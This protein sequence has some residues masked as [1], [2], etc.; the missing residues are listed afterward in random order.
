MELNKEFVF[1]YSKLPEYWNING[2]VKWEILKRNKKHTLYY[3]EGTP[4]KNDF[5][6]QAILFSLFSQIIYN[7]SLDNYKYIND[8]FSIKYSTYNILNRIS[9]KKLKFFIDQTCR[10]RFANS[11][12]DFINHSKKHMNDY[13]KFFIQISSHID[14]PYCKIDFKKLLISIIDERRFKEEFSDEKNDLSNLFFDKLKAELFKN[15]FTLTKDFI[16]E[17]LL[18]KKYQLKNIYGNEFPIELIGNEIFDG[19]AIYIPSSG[20]HRIEHLFYLNDKVIPEIQTTMPKVYIHSDAC[21]FYKQYNYNELRNELNKSF[22]F[23]IINEVIYINEHQSVVVLMLQRPNS[24]DYTWLIYFWGYENEKIIKAMI[25]KN[26]VTPIIYSYCD[27]ITSGM[28]FIPHSIP[29]IL[30]PLL[31]KDLGIKYIVTEQSW[32]TIKRLENSTYQFEKESL[33]NL[34]IDGL[35]SLNAVTKLNV[36]LTSKLLELNNDDLLS[37]LENVLQI[38]MEEELP[39]IKYDRL[40]L[41]KIKS[42]DK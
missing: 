33:H 12:G 16:F 32:K 23:K 41:K 31:N 19:G 40:I 26:I 25:N 29:T 18:P 27:G 2:T 36:D 14:V 21:D 7:Y 4:E 22:H 13:V 38:H 6:W 11:Y 1:S 15:K 28:G 34:L 42:N 10:K 5:L 39:Q 20:M 9:R 35:K 37:T 24:K 30:Y 8:H 17:E 3:F